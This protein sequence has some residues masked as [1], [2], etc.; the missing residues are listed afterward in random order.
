MIEGD[1]VYFRNAGISFKIRDSMDCASR[2]VIYA[3][4]CVGCDFSYIGE[5]K[6]FRQRMAGHRSK[7][8][9]LDPC[10][11]Q[12]SVHLNACDKG[13]KA[14][15]LMKFKEDCKITRLVYEEQI[16]KLVKADLNADKRNLLH[17]QVV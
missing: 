11:M 15:P 12:V 17:L 9:N 3:L 16:R 1:S 5:T 2:N 14:V 7:S 4:F 13:F 8:K 6:C 10:P